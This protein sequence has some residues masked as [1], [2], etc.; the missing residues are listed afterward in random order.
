MDNQVRSGRAAAARPAPPARPPASFPPSLPYP[1]AR[2]GPTLLG[3]GLP[4]PARRPPAQL[5]ARPQ[6]PGPLCGAGA[7]IPHPPP[8]PGQ[9]AADPPG[10]PGPP[11]LSVPWEA[12][13]NPS[14]AQIPVRHPP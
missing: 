3:P 8:P 1:P 9:S 11:L 10:N 6:L 14:L 13:R 5:C 4:A 7:P 2:P 12:P